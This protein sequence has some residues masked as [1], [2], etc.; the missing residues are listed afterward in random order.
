MRFLDEERYFSDC[1]VNMMHSNIMTCAK[2]AVI[3]A[4]TRFVHLLLILESGIAIG[5]FTCLVLV[6]TTDDFQ[7]Q[8]FKGCYIFC[9]LTSD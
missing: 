5:I 3:S 1:V 7:V 2:S 4:V 8:Y 6:P 9:S